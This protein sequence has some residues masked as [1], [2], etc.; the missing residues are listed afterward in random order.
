AGLIVD[1]VGGADRVILWQP[2]THTAAAYLPLASPPK[3]GAKSRAVTL[4]G[5]DKD[6]DAPF[7]DTQTGSRW[8]VAGRAVSGELK[9]WTLAW[10][11]G[12]QVKWCAWAAEYPTTTIHAPP[13]NKSLDKKVREIA[14]TAEFL[15]KVPKH[16]AKLEAVDA[17]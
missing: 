2:S 7:V 15:G 1:R 8:D 11:D 5:D 17:A 10:L 3:Q 4:R 13:D 6:A 12:V 14:C 9:G 16:F